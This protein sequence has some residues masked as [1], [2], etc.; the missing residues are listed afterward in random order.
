VRT[1]A[2]IRDYDFL[3]VKPGELEQRVL[4]DIIWV[5]ERYAFARK[6]EPVDEDIIF[7]YDADVF[8]EEIQDKEPSGENGDDAED[9]REN[10]SVSVQIEGNR[11]G[12]D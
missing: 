2:N 1:G 9:S 12:D 10:W 11:D 3:W 6:D 4:E 8:D 7:F 5:R